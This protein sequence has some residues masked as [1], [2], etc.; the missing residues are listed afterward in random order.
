MA[1][2]LQT[3]FRAA[4]VHGCD[5]QCPAVQK[6]ID[7]MVDAD[8]S[9]RATMLDWLTWGICTRD[10]L[11]DRILVAWA[12]VPLKLATGRSRDEWL[13][14]CN[15]LP[16]DATPREARLAALGFELPTEEQRRENLA[17]NIAPFVER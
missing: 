6:A 13:A 17:R 2:A 9:D 8:F 12:N 1:R 5:T 10:Q 4:L 7:A 15:R 11:V 3:M 16:D 14:I